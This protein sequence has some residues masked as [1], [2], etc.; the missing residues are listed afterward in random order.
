MA[1]LPRLFHGGFVVL[2]EGT[3]T[4]P[5]L[6]VSFSVSL[7]QFSYFSSL[8]STVGCT[9]FD[10]DNFKSESVMDEKTCRFYHTK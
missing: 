3:G 7:T 1:A 4:V 9:I 2:E 8:P 10:T 6:H 5:A